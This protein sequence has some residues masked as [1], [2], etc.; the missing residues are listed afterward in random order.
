MTEEK[1]GDLLCG[2][3]F[4][5]VVTP[6]AVAVTSSSSISVLG[7]LLC[8]KLYKNQKDG[9][10]TKNLHRGYIRSEIEFDSGRWCERNSQH[11]H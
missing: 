1:A 2:F 4:V 8:S 5:V 10:K 9:I 3:Y 11:R 7:S 6:H